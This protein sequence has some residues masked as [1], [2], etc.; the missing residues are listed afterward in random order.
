MKIDSSDEQLENAQRPISVNREFA[1]NVTVRRE[2]HQ[3][4]HCEGTTSTELGIQ[5]DLRAEHCAN[6]KTPIS[7][8]CEGYSNVILLSEVHNSKQ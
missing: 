8:R 7:C 6:A 4:K 3:S 1:S 5:I 2:M